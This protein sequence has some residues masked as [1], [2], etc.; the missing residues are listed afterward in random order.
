MS[1]AMA[2]SINKLKNDQILIKNVNAVQTC[3]ML[4]DICI[5]KT[6]TITYGKMSV[7]KYQFRN[8]LITVENVPTEDPDKF[9]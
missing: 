2:L 9:T 8:N 5:G 6:G 7:K 1:I 4:H 3:A